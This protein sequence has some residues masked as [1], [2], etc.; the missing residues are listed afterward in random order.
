MILR[1]LESKGIETSSVLCGSVFKPGLLGKNLGP[2]EMMLRRILRLGRLS[3]FG[4]VWT[5]TIIDLAPTPVLVKPWRHRAPMMTWVFALRTPSLNVNGT[6]VYQHLALANP[7]KCPRTHLRQ[8]QAFSWHFLLPIIFRLIWALAGSTLGRQSGELVRK[9]ET[10]NVELGRFWAY[11]RVL[12]RRANVITPA[13]IE[14][15]C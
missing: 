1:Y 10:V 13:R 7:T 8:L 12:I 9:F 11:L 3:A 6:G 2:W 15:A 4:V 14:Q 5:V